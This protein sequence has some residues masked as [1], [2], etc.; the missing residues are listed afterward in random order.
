MRLPNWPFKVFMIIS[1]IGLS[2]CSAA[3]TPTQAFVRSTRNPI[4]QTTT[5]AANTPTVTATDAPTDMPTLTPTQPPTATVD[6]N[7]SPIG[8]NSAAFAGNIT[9]F[10]GTRIG[11]GHTFQ[12][13]WQVRNTGACTWTTGYTLVYVNGARFGGDTAVS[14][15]V[16]VEPGQFVKISANLVAPTTAGTYTSYWLMKTDSGQFFGFGPT[17]NEP[18]HVTILILDLGFNS[19]PKP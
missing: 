4:T 1:L 17:S 5:V 7:A 10:D 15:P 12:K 18:V 8:C 13:T 16:N 19:T 2:A 6:P 3:A 14:M 11:P 9:I